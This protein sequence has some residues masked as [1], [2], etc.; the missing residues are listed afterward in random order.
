MHT[1]IC[2]GAS[3]GMASGVKLV[4]G[5][6]RPVV[7]V[8]GDSTFLH[9]G[10][11]GL[12]NAVYNQSPVTIV[13]LNNRATAMTGGQQHPGTGYTLQGEETSAV[14]FIELVKALGVKHIF[15]I[16]GY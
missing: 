14:N 12:L 2:M 9:S 1:C 15:S 8:I 7:G 13:I 10:I 16:D 5:S 11:T 4:D 6:K 3:I